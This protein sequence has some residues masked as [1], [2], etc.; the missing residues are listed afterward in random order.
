MRFL[1]ILEGRDAK[2]AVV[3]VVTRDRSILDAA[4]RALNERLQ[5]NPLYSVPPRRGTGPD[6]DAIDDV[7]ESRRAPDGA[8]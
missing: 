1:Q 8:D 4:T 6:A 7:L 2:T 5:G 3:V